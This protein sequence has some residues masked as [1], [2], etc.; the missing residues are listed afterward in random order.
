MAN[1]I[2]FDCCWSINNIIWMEMK[3]TNYTDQD[4]SRGFDLCESV[5]SVL[6]AFY[7]LKTHRACCN[8]GFY[9]DD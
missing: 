2:E 4:D 8:D 3:N 9:G 5:Q 6:F 1:V 7:K